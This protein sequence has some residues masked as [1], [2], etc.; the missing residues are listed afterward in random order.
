MDT[1]I[2]YS[3]LYLL[4]DRALSAIN[5]IDTGFYLSGGTCLHRFYTERRYSDD[6]DLFCNDAD[7]FRDY[8]RETLEAL[9]DR[10]LTVHTIIDTRD[11]IRLQLDD[12][13]KVD[14][15]NDRVYRLGRSARSAEGFRI[16]NVLNILA[17]KI[18]AI[19]GRDEP[20]DL[21]DLATIA[22]F[23]EFDWPLIIEAAERK[24]VFERD[25]LVHRI[26]SFPVSLLD[27]LAVRDPA[28]LHSVSER[29]G[30]IAD[31]I[32]DSA[33]NRPARTGP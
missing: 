15:V 27:R 14:M 16:D 6:L 11:F 32:L 31:A 23:A 24:C 18:T 22:D 5:N 28:Y 8:S 25:Y 17:N 2:D 7:L 30:G 33:H 21:F 19:I 3:A 9:R 20:K 1:D 13:L 4:Q 29:L 10:G 12:S 26:R